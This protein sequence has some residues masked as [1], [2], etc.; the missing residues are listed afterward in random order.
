MP[1]VSWLTKISIGRVSIAAASN[2]LMSKRQHSRAEPLLE[3][4]QEG[5]AAGASSARQAQR[6]QR[7]DV[8]ARDRGGEGGK[9]SGKG[10]RH[11]FGVNDGELDGPAGDV[12]QQQEV[13]VAD[14]GP[15]KK[16]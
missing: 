2:Y 10:G 1:T 12:E 15:P 3:A 5:P 8:G 11:V 14:Y 9:Q 7:A 6:E 13:A 16:D 4:Q